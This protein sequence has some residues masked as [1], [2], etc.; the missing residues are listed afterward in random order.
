MLAKCAA[1]ETVRAFYG[2]VGLVGQAALA[3]LVAVRSPKTGTEIPQLPGK[4]LRA[5]LRGQD[6]PHAHGHGERM[7]S[8]LLRGVLNK[9]VQKTS[10]C[11]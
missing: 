3:K 11:V 1:R 8:Q 6:E 10:Y 9:E 7:R 4:G 5:A 2:S